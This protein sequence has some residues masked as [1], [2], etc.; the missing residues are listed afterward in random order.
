[1]MF[2]TLQALIAVAPILQVE[3]RRKVIREWSSFV[4]LMFVADVVVLL[5]GQRLCWMSW[6]V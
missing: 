5:L 1:M 4:A 3:E 2:A 6:C